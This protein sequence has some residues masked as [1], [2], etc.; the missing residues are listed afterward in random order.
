[1]D[2]LRTLDDLNELI[3]GTPNFGPLTWGLDRD[4]ISMMLT[5]LRASLP[6]EVK[7]AQ[8]TVRESDRIIDQAKE[9]AK[10]VRDSAA[11]ECERM[12]TEAG[13][14]CFGGSSPATAASER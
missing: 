7:A 5:K 9:D 4:E 12:L 11:K 1:M 13:K 14:N 3:Q 10:A 6:Q 2:I 8:S